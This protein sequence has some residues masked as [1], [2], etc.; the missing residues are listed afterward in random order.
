MTGTVDCGAATWAAGCRKVTV[1]AA[2]SYGTL[3]SGDETICNGGDPSNIVFGTPASGGAGTFTYQWYYKDGVVD[4]PTGTS[5]TGWTSISGATSDSYNPPSGLTASRTYAVQV[6]VTG[7]VDCGAATWA[8]GCRKVTV[9]N[10]LLAGTAGSNQM[11]CNG[12]TPAPLTATAPGGGSGTFTYQWQQWNGTSW[13]SVTGGSGGTTLTY[14][15]PALTATTKYRLQQTDTYCTP[16]DVVNTNELT[17][18]V[19]PPSTLPASL[20]NLTG[21]TSDDDLGDCTKQIQ[22]THPSFPANACGPVNLTIFFT[23][24]TPAI[25]L[26][27]GGTVTPGGNTTY[28]FY[29]GV[30]QVTYN[31]TDQGGNTSSVS[32]NVTITDDEDPVITYC[33]PDIEQ[34]TD[35]GEEFATVTVGTATATDNCS[36]T[37]SGVRSDGLALSA[38]YPIGVTTITWT[39][40]DGAGLTDQCTQTITVYPAY[41]LTLSIFLQGPFNPV[42]QLMNT[43]LRSNGQVP[44]SQPYNTTP[45][46]YTT[47]DAVTSLEN[48]IVDW[49]LIELREDDMITRHARKAGLLHAD[50]SVTVSF[51]GL[52]TEGEEYYV[53][54]WH[55]NHITVMSDEMIPIPISGAF[56]DMTTLDACYGTKPMIQLTS[57]IYGMIAGEVIPDGQLKYSGVSNDRGQILAKLLDEGNTLV[58]DTEEDGYWSED[59]NMNNELRYIGNIPTPNDRGYIINNISTLLPTTFLTEIYYCEVP[60]VWGGLKSLVSGNGPVNIHLDGTQQDLRVVLTTNELIHNG[61]LDNLQFALAWKAYDTEIEG[62]LNVFYSDYMIQQQGGPIQIGDTKYLVFVTVTPTYLPV[63]WNPGEDLTVLNFETE[64]G[65]LFADR[66]WIADDSFTQQNN[67]SY[68][69][70]VWGSDHT[71]MIDPPVVVSVNDLDPMTLIR[72]YPNPVH[73]GKL[74]VDMMATRNQMLR[75]HMFD[76]SG[77]ML[78]DLPWQAFSGHSTKVID[79]SALPPGAYMLNVV[80]EKVNYQ[81]KIILLTL[82]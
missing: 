67:A 21:N 8:A 39:A 30:T 28:D 26:P 68:Y 69:V 62:M 38:P 60:G 27:T 47:A 58:S 35:P 81:K 14:S 48:D 77:T 80:G 37:V 6:D 53:V 55:R 45:W 22:L 46:N 74:T 10:I 5:T 57:S 76:V 16:D 63:E 1:Y 52:V 82:N 64:T 12:E 19:D 25:P 7:T 17:I 49:L 78:I 29:A 32:F 71:G 20:S 9:Y 43:D 79:L 40:T 65:A 44:Q 3:A 41:R 66:M 23:A 2:V 34:L 15:P 11:I 42:T 13:V 18:T 4:C 54:V 70:S 61:V 72:V 24:I 56:L 73:N 51:Y 31:S 50:G 75:I 36:V 59:V 33:P